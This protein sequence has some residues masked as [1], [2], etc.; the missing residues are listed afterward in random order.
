MEERIELRRVQGADINIFRRFDITCGINTALQAA[1]TLGLVLLTN[2]AK[3]RKDRQIRSLMQMQHD[4]DD[5]ALGITLLEVVSVVILNIDGEDPGDLYGTVL[6][7]D[8]FGSVNLFL[9]DRSDVQPVRPGD[10]AELV[11]PD[12]AISAADDLVIDLH[13]MDRGRDP[14]PDNEVSRGEV[15]WISREPAS[16]N[17]NVVRST[18]VAGKHGSAEVSYAVLT[19]AVVA[20]IEVLLING[21]GESDPDVH[22][23]ITAATEMAPGRLLNYD[24]FRQLAR[25]EQVSVPANTNIPLRR[26]VI[27]AVLGSPLTVKVDLWDRDSFPDPSPDDHIAAGSVDFQ[28]RFEGTDAQQI[29][30]P[31]GKVEVRVTWSVGH[32]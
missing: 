21:D 12:R 23:T 9:R 31:K 13:L 2:K 29:T 24:L 19:D 5:V 17:C 10:R 27:T 20:T 7:R 6:V 16:R 18:V 25:S 32:L 15:V 1:A 8:S 28:P 30:G 14:S 26:R 3:P 11:W 4:Y 22:G